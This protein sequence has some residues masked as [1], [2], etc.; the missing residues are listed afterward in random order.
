MKLQ[1]AGGFVVKTKIVDGSGIHT[2][3]TKV[4]INVCHAPEVAQPPI[5]FDPAVV[6]P[7]IVNNEWEVPLVV[8]AEKEDTDKKG[9]ALFV[10]DCCMNSE[11]FRWVQLSKELRLIVIEWCIEAVE[12]AYAL[13]LEREYAL[14]KMLIKGELL[15]TEIGDDVIKDSFDKIG[16]NEALALVPESDDELPSLFGAGAR[17]LIEEIDGMSLSRNLHVPQA[18]QDTRMQAVKPLTIRYVSRDDTQVVVCEGLAAAP[19]VTHMPRDSCV[20]VGATRV[21]LSGVPRRAVFVRP[22]SV[23]YLVCST[24]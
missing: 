7:L 1:P 24:R 20:L 9:N 11:C 12:T 22:T 18:L 23:L 4:F 8:L 14:P 3:G 17:P 2:Y 10:Y 16:E 15:H 13:V 5:R 21:P 19:R 6:F